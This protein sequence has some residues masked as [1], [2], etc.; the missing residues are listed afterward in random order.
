MGSEMCI[1]DRF[2]TAGHCSHNNRSNNWYHDGKA[3]NGFIGSRTA[4]AFA[5]TNPNNPKSYDVMRVQTA[6]V[7]ASDDVFGESGDLQ[8]YYLN[9]Q[10]YNGM[11]VCKSGQVTNVTCGTITKK[12]DTW[13]SNTCN[14]TQYGT[15]A[16]YSSSGGDSGSPVYRRVTLQS[17]APGLFAVGI[18]AHSG[19]HF[20]RM[21]DALVQLN[22]TLVT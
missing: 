5:T 13:T 17:G 11:P 16:N 8:G 3:G 14:C 10:L 18:H 4:T 12:W 1:R 21:R 6:D 22:V 7:Q 2:L 9:S 15:D 20:A 19:G